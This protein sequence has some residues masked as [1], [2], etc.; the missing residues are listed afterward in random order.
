MI[1]SLKNLFFLISFGTLADMRATLSHLPN[2]ASLT[3]LGL[4]LYLISP[5]KARA[6]EYHERCM[7]SAVTSTDY[8]ECGNEWVE[9]EESA[10]TLAW[11]RVYNSFEA[12][13]A[14]ARL[15]AE[16]RLWIA[17]KDKACSLY[18]DTRSFGSMGWSL[19]LPSCRAQIIRERIE[20]LNSYEGR[21]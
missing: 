16:Q 2:L 3:I 8:A 19:E 12:G 11:R 4:S 18:G 20:L 7:A 6:D 15:L 5:E 14:K 21:E 17:Y 13:T 10:L 1:E 9:R